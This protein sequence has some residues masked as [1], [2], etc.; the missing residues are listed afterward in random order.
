MVS[1]YLYRYPRLSRM[2]TSIAARSVRM[3]RIDAV[4]GCLCLL[5]VAFA[6]GV[7]RV[8]FKPT[9]GDTAACSIALADDST[10]KLSSNCDLS[11]AS[12]AS[13][14]SN[15]ELI[16]VL[17]TKINRIEV[18]LNSKMAND[19]DRV[20]SDV[21]QLQGLMARILACED[22]KYANANF[23]SMADRCLPCHADCE[24]CSGPDYDTCTKCA[25][26]KIFSSDK[27]Y[28]PCTCTSGTAATGQ[29]CTTAFDATGDVHQCVACAN[30]FFLYNARCHRKCT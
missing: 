3:V 16:Q 11:V 25:D 27:C 28:D 23:T 26:E 17:H 15:A 9:N 2:F 22:G 5:C 29:S 24:H 19:V 12:G 1:A 8:T 14:Q 30:G 6:A 10:S 20:D 18:E 13:V 21:V 7:P 4:R